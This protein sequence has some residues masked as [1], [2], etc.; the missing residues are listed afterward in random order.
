MK[1][2]DKVAD[3]SET[4]LAGADSFDLYLKAIGENLNS[5]I[6]AFDMLD[7]VVGGKTTN[8]RGSLIRYGD[9]SGQ[10]KRC[11]RLRRACPF[12]PDGDIVGQAAHVSFWHEAGI[13]GQAAQVCF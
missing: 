11:D 7:M 5:M 12:W 6:R 8:R 10:E 1:N 2:V 13:H 3:R 4:L 9:L